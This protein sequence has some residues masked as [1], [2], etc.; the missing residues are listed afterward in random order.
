QFQL[1]LVRAV[2]CDQPPL[3]VRFAFRGA[4]IDAI[5]NRRA[6]RSHSHGMRAAKFRPILRTEWML[7][8]RAS[9]QTEKRQPHENPSRNNDSQTCAILFHFVA[10]RIP[11]GLL[12]RSSL[13][14]RRTKNNT[15]PVATQ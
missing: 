5:Q 7:F 8:R 2:G 11:G 15:S 6:I 9:G 10:P 12:L 3:L 13:N 14:P 1:V 4:E